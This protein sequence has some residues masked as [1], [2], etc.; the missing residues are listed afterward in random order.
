LLNASKIPNEPNVVTSFIAGVLGI[1]LDF[2]Y[3]FV[4]L[5]TENY[6]LGLS[7][8]LFT[9]ITRFLMVPF[10]VSSQKSMMKTQRIQP[11]V[12]KINKK[13][14]DS[15]DPEVLKKKNAEIQALY[16]KEKINPIAS[17]LPLFL[18]LP[19]FFAL[20]Y[21][22]QVPYLYIGALKELYVDKLANV[23]LSINN[24][25]QLLEPIILPKLLN[26]DINIGANY[27]DQ[28]ARVLARFTEAEWQDFFTRVPA[29][30]SAQIEQV[31][32]ILMQIENTGMFF[33]LKLTETPGFR[34]SPAIIIPILSA[35]TSFLSSYIMTRQQKNTSSDPNLVNT[36]KTMTYVTPLMMAFFTIT[37]PIG[38]GIYWI[39]SNVFHIVQQIVIN[40]IYSN[41][42]E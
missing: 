24:S 31:K 14:G 7:I 23:V 37:T 19:I 16:A 32:S 4:S 18:Q 17:C 15:K 29:E 34:L 5:F 27:P 22:M 41:K 8:I 10:A 25:L 3:G 1:I 28:L 40:R 20:S 35:V 42:G 39:T 33:G 36:Q 13:Y 6:V 11:E 30:F 26:R 2:I 38:V 12:N 9:I 21:I